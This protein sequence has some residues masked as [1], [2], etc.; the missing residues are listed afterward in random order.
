MSVVDPRITAAKRNLEKFSLVIPVFSP[1]G[2]VG[3]TFIT[4]LMAYSLTLDNEFTISLL[5]ADFT[6]PSLHIVLGLDESNLKIEEEMGIK[7]IR[8]A[9]EI[10][11]MTLAAFVKDLTVPLRGNDIVNVVRELLAITR[12]SGKIMLIDSPPGFSDTHLEF[13]R[14]LIEVKEPKVLLVSTPTTLAL[15][16]TER[17]TKTLLSENIKILG[18]IGNMCLSNDDEGSIVQKAQ[19]LT[20]PYLGCIPY[21]S[22]AEKFYGTSMLELVKKIGTPLISITKIIKEAIE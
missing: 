17:I 3:K 1:K 15:K 11:L 12:W 7:P 6:N 18:L 22:N 4:A 13:L 21:I 20:I 2:G 14:L 5:D 10:E 9:P 8:V 19:Q 16:A